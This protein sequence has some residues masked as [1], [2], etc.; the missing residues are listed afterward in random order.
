MIKDFISMLVL[1]LCLPFLNL[2][3]VAGVVWKFIR[4]FSPRNDSFD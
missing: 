3:V 2:L 1:F 4:S